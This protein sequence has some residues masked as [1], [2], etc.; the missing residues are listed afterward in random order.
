[1]L[2]HG[3]DTAI[4]KKIELKLQKTKLFLANNAL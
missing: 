1:M 4:K 3:M 2:N